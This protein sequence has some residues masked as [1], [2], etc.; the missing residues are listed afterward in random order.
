MSADVNDILS[1]VTV[2]KLFHQHQLPLKCS[3]AIKYVQGISAYRLLFG[4]SNAKVLCLSYRFSERAKFK[5][6]NVKYLYFAI[7]SGAIW[8]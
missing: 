6:K 3:E 8:W 4:T 1:L 7:L 2:Y 5:K